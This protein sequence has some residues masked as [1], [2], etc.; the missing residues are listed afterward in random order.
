MCLKFTYFSPLEEAINLSSRWL[1]QTPK[2][3]GVRQPAVYD[4]CERWPSPRVAL[5][6]CIPWLGIFFFVLPLAWTP[7]QA[8]ERTPKFPIFVES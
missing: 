6:C 1:A 8:L 5:R 3:K 7:E 2:N 4:V